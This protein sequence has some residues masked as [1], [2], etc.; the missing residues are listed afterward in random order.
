M[1]KAKSGTLDGQS[2][3]GIII[4]FVHNKMPGQENNKSGLWETWVFFQ[5]F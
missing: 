1:N 4:V 2:I 3:F 5:D